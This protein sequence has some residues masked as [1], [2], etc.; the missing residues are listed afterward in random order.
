MIPLRRFNDVGVVAFEETL[1]RIEQGEDVD[2][3]PLLGDTLVTETIST[4][5]VVDVRPFDDRFEAA[6][7]LHDLLRPYEGLIGDVERD[8]GMWTWLSAAWLDILAP[9]DANG[10]RNLKARARWIPAVDDYKTYY[11]H[12]LA[13]P[14][15]IYRAH[16]TDPER[17]RAALAT[18]VEKPGEVV[19]QLASRQEIITS[20]TLMAAI[21]R[22]YYNPTAGCL[23]AGAGSKTGGSARR[24]VDVIQQFDLTWDVYGMNPDEFYELLPTEFD[25]FKNP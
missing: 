9:K 2:V 21:T 16:R 6:K 10:V 1:D 8:R 25:R 3:A 14:F 18:A 24:L 17:V 22:L 23:K 13:G 19:E 7:Y 11:R 4:T 15:R 20:S 12:L 5:A